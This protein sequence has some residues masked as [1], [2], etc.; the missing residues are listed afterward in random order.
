MKHLLCQECTSNTTAALM[1]IPAAGKFYFTHWADNL[2]SSI[3]PHFCG[4]QLLFGHLDFC[5][6][7]IYLGAIIQDL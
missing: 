2:K 3:L 1:D 7:K 5:R 6:V 4:T